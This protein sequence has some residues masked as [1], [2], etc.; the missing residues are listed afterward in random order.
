MRTYRKLD[1]KLTTSLS[2]HKIYILYNASFSIKLNKIRYSLHVTVCRQCKSLLQ[3]ITI[4]QS[5]PPSRITWEHP[6]PIK[7]RKLRCSRKNV[8]LKEALAKSFF[9]SC[10]FYLCRGERSKQW[11]LRR[12]Q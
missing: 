7:W 11:F 5:R 12:L 9:V 3:S 2:S 4:S 1:K 10:A 6:K 8:Q